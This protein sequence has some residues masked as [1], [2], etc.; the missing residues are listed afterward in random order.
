MENNNMNIDNTV[1]NMENV[2][3]ETVEEVKVD[4]ITSAKMLPKHK[5]YYRYI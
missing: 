1:E 3:V 2:T 5:G 4:K